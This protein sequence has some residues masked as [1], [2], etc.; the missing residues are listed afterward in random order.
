MKSAEPASTSQTVSVIVAT[1]SRP[2][3][4]RAAVRSILAQDYPGAIEVVVVFDQTPVDVQV[5]EEFTGAG[6]A[7]PRRVVIRANDRSPG[8]AGARNCGALASTGA[9]LAFCDDDDAW[10]TPKLRKQVSAMAA[11]RAGLSVS[12]IEITMGDRT[13]VRI[14]SPADLTVE[15]LARRRVMEAHPSTVV[16][17]RAAFDRI[18]LVDELIPGSYAEDYDWMLRAVADQRVAVVSEPLV[19][20]LWHP[21]SFFSTQWETIIEALDYCVAKHESIRRSPQGMARIYGQKAFAFAALGKRVEARHWA[22]RS[23]R[24]SPKERRSYLA[25]ATSLRLVSASR[26]VALANSRGKNI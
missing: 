14:P 22:W 25:L 23:L 13:H 18:G 24:L 26:V 2:G 9:M 1:R 10:T 4:M 5:P 15:E 11:E 12:G 8:L 19:H 6:E 7:G 16:V 3:L 17:T 21:G 20:V